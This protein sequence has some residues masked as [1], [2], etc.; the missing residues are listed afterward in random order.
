MSVS[1]TLSRAGTR[2]SGLAVP[3][4]VRILF[5]GASCPAHER[6]LEWKFNDSWQTC[7]AACASWQKRD[8]WNVCAEWE[9]P[10]D[11]S[12]PVGWE[13]PTDGA[14][15]ADGA[16]LETPTD[17]SGPV[18]WEN[19]MVGAS[20]AHVSGMRAD[21]T[22]GTPGVWQTHGPQEGGSNCSE[23]P[24]KEANRRKKERKCLAMSKQALIDFREFAFDL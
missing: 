3:T 21:G 8:D 23:G 13:N 7:G 5:F 14:S 16:E 12:G 2:M 20:S 9:T 22:S 1:W 19:P 18:G 17:P 4:V 10:T 6:D 11:P 15:S 24:W